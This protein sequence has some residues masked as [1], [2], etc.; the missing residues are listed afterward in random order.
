MDWFIYA[1]L[2]ALSFTVFSIL[3]RKSLLKK[4]DA[5]AF[6]V[7]NDLVTGLILFCFI[8]FFTHTISLSLIHIVLIVAASLLFAFSSLLFTK[9]RQIEEVG[10]VSIIRQTSVFWIFIGGYI[11]FDEPLTLQKLLGIVLLFLGT[12]IVLWKKE[13]ISVTKGVVYIFL[14]AV[15]LSISSLIAKNIVD[16]S[17]PPVVYSGMLFFLAGLW[18]L[19]F[20]KQKERIRNELLL[21]KWNILFVS[22]FLGLSILLLY[23]GYQTG[24]VSKV[25]PVYS[26]YVIFSVIAGMIFLHERADIKRKILGSLVALVGV[27]LLVAF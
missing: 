15:S 22:F 14:G 17:L 27:A 11:F 25:F 16:N 2:S 19:P 6:T 18:L 9:G 8:P 1:L 21:Q 12:L 3:I 26:S 13:K 10:V 5:T 7:L 4:S 23:T 24:E 20:V